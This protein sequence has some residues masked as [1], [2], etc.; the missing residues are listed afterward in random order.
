M[1]FE[2]FNGLV[3]EMA[4]GRGVPADPE[5]GVTVETATVESGFVAF[6]SGGVGGGGGAVDE[7][8]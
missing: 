4:I 3:D 2:G 7:V 1:V 5:S 6:F 8:G